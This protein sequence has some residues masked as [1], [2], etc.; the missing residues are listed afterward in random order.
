MSNHNGGP[1]IHD[2]VQGYL[3]LPLGGLIQ[4]RCCLIKDQDLRA[5]ND[6]SGDGDPLFLAP[7]ELAALDPA[8][9]VK[10]VVQLEGL[11]LGASPV[12]I[13]LDSGEDSLLFFLFLKLLQDICR[14][15][16]LLAFHF[17]SKNGPI[18]SELRVKGCSRIIKSVLYGCG[19]DELKSIRDFGGLID[20]LVAR[21]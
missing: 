17:L 3:D 16:E 8:L 12:D 10:S 19:L 7:R 1:V 20:L 18:L 15:S 11:L 4:G 21:F 13:A 9:D 6:G 5:S 2:V 14:L